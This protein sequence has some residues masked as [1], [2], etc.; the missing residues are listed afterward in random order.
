MTARYLPEAARQFIR[1]CLVGLLNTAITYF[2]FLLLFKCIK[3]PLYAS[4]AISYVL[5]LVNS[6]FFN[7]NWTFGSGGFKVKEL[8]LFLAVFLVSYG[9][10][11]AF[12][13]LM[14]HLGIRE[15]IA[16]LLGM[17][18]YTGIGFFGNKFFTFRKGPQHG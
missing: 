2:S 8:A 15:E 16:Q 9:V 12:F 14:H 6:F 10:Q 11:F 3:V 5:G 18:V 4:N 7:K 13:A 17:I 1:F